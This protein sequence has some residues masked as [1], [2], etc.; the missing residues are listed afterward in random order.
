MKKTLA[1][2]IQNGVNNLPREKQKYIQ[3]GTTNTSTQIN[4]DAE[5]NGF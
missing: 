5:Y 3:G 2:V 4:T 1:D